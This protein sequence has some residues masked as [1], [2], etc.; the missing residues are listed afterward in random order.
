M[1]AITKNLQDIDF[2]ELKTFVTKGRIDL[3]YAGH[4]MG[5]RTKE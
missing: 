1:K 4:A 2:K 3:Q 5:A